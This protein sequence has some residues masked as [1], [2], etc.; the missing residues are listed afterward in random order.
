MPYR[1]KSG[2]WAVWVTPSAHL[3]QVGITIPWDRLV[4]D[5][6]PHFA[7]PPFVAVVPA[8][9]PDPSR[10][11]T[12]EE[13][14]EDQ[15]KLVWYSWILHLGGFCLQ[16]AQSWIYFLD[17]PTGVWEHQ[18]STGHQ[19]GASLPTFRPEDAAQEAHPEQG[20]VGNWRPG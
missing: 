9:S 5:A 10:N 6:T 2:H 20:C 16:K 18:P 17:P 3:G 13:R 12:K 7:A 1:L 15:Q 4:V 8:I 11:R 19:A 14:R